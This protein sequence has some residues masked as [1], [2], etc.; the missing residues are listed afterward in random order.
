[1]NKVVTTKIKW[2][3]YPYIPFGKITVIQGD[4]GD[5][6]TMVVLAIVATITTGAM[7]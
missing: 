4:P 7:A 5:G 2:L 1:M 6:K 3:W